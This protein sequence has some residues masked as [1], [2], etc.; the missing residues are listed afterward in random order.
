MQGKVFLG[1]QAEPE[2]EYSF[3]YRGR[4][5]ERFD[6]TRVVRDKR[7]IY[8][9]NY[10]PYVKWGQH[11]DY[12]WHMAAMQAWEDYFKAG[13][14]DD[15]T[16]LFFKTK[17]WVEELYDCQTDSDCVTNLATRLEYQPVVARMRQALKDWQLKI[18]DPGLLPE[19]EM[20]RRADENWT[21]IYQMVRDPKLYNLPAYL[22]A[23]DVALAKNNSNLK[24]LTGYLADADSGIRYWGA[25]GLVMLDKLDTAAVI[26][27]KGCL[28]DESLDVQAMAAWAL[29][30]AGDKKD[31]Q[32]CLIRLLNQESYVTLKVMNIIDWMGV[33]T[34]PYL[35]A[36]KA[37]K[38]GKADSLVKNNSKLNPTGDAFARMQDFLLHPDKRPAIDQRG[39]ISKDEDLIDKA[40]HN[41][42]DANGKPYDEKLP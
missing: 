1:P 42:K 27:L 3:S 6:E 17:P 11:H 38:T 19:N 35:P 15:I 8:I 22:A 20:T 21:T 7:F 26:A 34:T 5:D 18:Y 29:I 30:K 39:E 25:C 41:L 9:K 32:E 13:K 2:P 14:T 16:G 12:L 36:I 37:L 40:E 10:M 31:G 33:D 24:T 4:M 23:S 28:K